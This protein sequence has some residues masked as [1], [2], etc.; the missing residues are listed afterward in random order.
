MFE[1]RA[2]VYQ[3]RNLLGLDSSGLSD[4]FINI[5]IGSQSVKSETVIQTNNPK[6]KLTFLISDIYLY[7]DLEFILNHPPQMTIE[8]F[9]EDFGKVSHPTPSSIH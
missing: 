5:T 9:D 6:W 1:L 8:L 7:G 4:P 3:G 2:H